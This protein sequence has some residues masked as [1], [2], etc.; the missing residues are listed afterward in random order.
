LYYN[1]SSAGGGSP[2]YN[3]GFDIDRYFY[4]GYQQKF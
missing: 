1:V 4:F 2:P 3:P